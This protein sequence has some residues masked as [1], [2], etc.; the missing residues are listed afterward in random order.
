MSEDWNRYHEQMQVF[1]NKLLPL[2]KLEAT[3]KAVYDSVF[4][5][6][7]F[8]RMRRRGDF[9]SQIMARMALNHLVWKY[10]FTRWAFRQLGKLRRVKKSPGGHSTPS[11]DQQS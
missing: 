1:E 10:R 7:Y 6:T 9:H 5:P 3:K 11:K 8:L 4:T 2:P